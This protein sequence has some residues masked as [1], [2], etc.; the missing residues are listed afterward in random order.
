MLKKIYLILCGED[1]QKRP[2]SK[3]LLELVRLDNINNIEFKIVVSGYSSF[4]L[5]ANESQSLGLSKYLIENNIS[6]E[7]I[8]LEEESM[9]TLGNMV[10]SYKIIESLIR[11]NNLEKI[12]IVLITEGFHMER[13]KKLFLKIFDNI[14]MVNP[15]ITFDFISANTSNISSFFWRRKLDIIVEKIKRNIDLGEDIT[16]YFKKIILVHKKYMLDYAI[17]DMILTDVDIF[18]LKTYDDFRNFLFSLPIYNEKYTPTSKYLVRYS[19]Y[20]SAIEKLI[21]NRKENKSISP[22]STHY[23]TLSNSLT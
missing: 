9:D 19:I 10:F 7:N 21:N 20:S 17:L 15:N 16:D 6:K 13:S 5:N 12:E 2:R 11:Q 22:H 1:E 14:K 23:E 3:K 4:N 8:I 18:R